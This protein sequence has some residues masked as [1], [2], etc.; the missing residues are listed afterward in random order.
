MEDNGDDTWKK[1][2]REDT[3]SS[4]NWWLKSLEAIKDKSE[5]LF[6]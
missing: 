6:V 4:H 5:L 2:M 1:L 3:M